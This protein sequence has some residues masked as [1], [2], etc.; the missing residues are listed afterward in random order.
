MADLTDRFEAAAEAVQG[1]SSRPS[2]DDMLALYALYK[3]ATVGDVRGKRPGM[4]DFA[5]GAKY[6]AWQKI[7]GMTADE[8]MAKYIEKV[9]SLT[10]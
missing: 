8:A 3:Q 6:D 2:N 7:Q 1:L 10:G 4:M 9:E 5:G